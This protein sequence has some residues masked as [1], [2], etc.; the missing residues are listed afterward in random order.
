MRAKKNIQLLIKKGLTIPAPDTVLLGEEV[1]LDKISGDGVV[2]YPGCRIFGEKTV[3]LPGVKL[4][5]EAP[6]TVENCQVGPD[7][8]LKG[9]FFREAVFLAGAS[10]GSGAH[11][12]EGCLLEEQ[13]NCAHA[14]GLKQT[15]LFPFV[16]LGSLVNFCDCL[17]AGGTSRKNHSE[18]GSSYIHF[19]YTANQDKVTA[20]LIGDVPKGVMLD[21]PPIFLGGQG[22]LVGPVQIG[23][24]SVI[25]A[26]VVCRKDVPEN[27][28]VVRDIVA[29][30][31]VERLTIPQ[32]PHLY[33]H[34]Q[35]RVTHNIAYLAHLLALQQWYRHVRS[36]F[37]E[38]DPLSSLL[39]SG[40]LETISVAV[41]E[42]IKRLSALA[43]KMPLSIERY[44]Q[45]RPDEEN[46]LIL[47]QK[48]E[49]H[50]KW[51]DVVAFLRQFPETNGDASKRD[52]FLDEIH[53]LIRDKGKN[54][55]A[56]IQ[57]LDKSW[58]AQGTAWL[59]DIVGSVRNAASD[60]LPLF[61]NKL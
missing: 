28:L 26:G 61:Y 30:T 3:M 32:Y 56:V 49:F 16:T 41:E 54:Y 51:Q 40:A 42:R 25:A 20:S 34:V 46:T 24:G 52:P 23:Y 57:G 36:F 43:K 31:D 5:Y 13:S 18:V 22:G 45:E 35:K 4:G 33:G 60:I 27:T 9:G 38:G 53:H 21:Q 1:S 44:R 58:S 10:M 37:M 19:N 55:I 59:D 2:I 29:N 17:M 48:K 8:E 47:E 14:V 6:A 12:R 50:E 11:V 7:V 15:I 39:F